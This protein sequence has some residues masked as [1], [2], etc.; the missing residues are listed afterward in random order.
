MERAA[1]QLA[2]TPLFYHYCLICQ[3]KSPFVFVQRGFIFSRTLVH[4]DFLSPLGM[5]MFG[6]AVLLRNNQTSVL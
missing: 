1:K 3:I 4:Q 6:I 5:A 2:E